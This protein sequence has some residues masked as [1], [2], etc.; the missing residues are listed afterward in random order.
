MMKHSGWKSFS[1][2]GLAGFIAF[3][4][5]PDV[6]LAQTAP[7]A[8]DLGSE[9]APAERQRFPVTPESRAAALDMME[10]AEVSKAMEAI[11]PGVFE[12]MKDAFLQQYQGRDEIVSAVFDEVLVRFADR[13]TEVI[14]EIA[15]IYASEFSVEDLQAQAAYYR[16]PVGRR[17]VERQVFVQ[18]QSMAIG[19]EWGA[20]IAREVVGEVTRGLRERG[21][22]S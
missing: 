22:T 1:L 13:Q 6:A 15:A 11:L 3:L 2:L 12:M 4:T 10:A 9:S 8:V 17:M 20:R 14:S 5:V 7:L 16:S 18:Q 19:Q 21:V